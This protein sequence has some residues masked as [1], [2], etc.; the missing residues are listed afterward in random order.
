MAKFLFV[1]HAPLPTAEAAPP[2]PEEMQQVMGA[3]M[4]WADKV[5]PGL[6]DLGTP[7]DGGIEVTADG[8]A[9]STRDVRGYSIIEADDLAAALAL[10]QVHPHLAMPGGCSIEVH[11]A[12]PLPGM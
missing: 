6:V 10:A 8:T 1:Y 4:A 3:W 5:G 7:L 9:P 12:Q 11:A 2:S